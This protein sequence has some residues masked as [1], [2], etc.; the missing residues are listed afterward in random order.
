MAEERKW[1]LRGTRQGLEGGK[2]PL[3]VG[4]G[5]IEHRFRNEKAEKIIYKIHSKFLVM[6][7][8]QPIVYG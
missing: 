8:M 1:D 2:C 4:E 7:R 3:C 5:I 6:N